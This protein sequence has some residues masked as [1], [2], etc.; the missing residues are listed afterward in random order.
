MNPV[1]WVAS[2]LLSVRR[3]WVQLG[4]AVLTNSYFPTFLKHVPCPGLNCCSCPA[5][6][7]ACPIGGLQH[8][9]AARQA[10]L[11]LGGALG[12][13]GLTTGRLTCGWLCPFGWV[14]DLAYKL[15]TRKWSPR[16]R[17]P[18][19]RFVVLILLVL[20]LP[21]LTGEQWFSKV[22]PAGT[23]EA[24]IPWVLLSEEVRKQA[25]GLFAFK[26]GTLIGLLGWMVVTRRPFCRYFCPLG[27]IYAL[28]NPVSLL[29]IS[30]DRAACSGCVQC[31]GTCPV[32]IDPPSQVNSIHCIHCLEC[33][34]A[35]PTGALRL[36]G[37]A[38]P[39]PRGAADWRG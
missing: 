11:Y 34:R 9:A 28:F 14:Q 1:P 36:V 15:P 29:R 31:R 21:F 12:L 13:V 39:T 4:A 3:G 24:G 18:W 20:V 7:F 10:P 33:V 8:F 37:P 6:A 26:I 19:L 2:S 17:L 22:C 25:G 30:V 16:L 38:V 35:C 32:E 23:L 5:A 27:A